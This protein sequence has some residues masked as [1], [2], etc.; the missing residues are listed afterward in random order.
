MSYNI[1]ELPGYI[2]TA[3]KVT[4]LTALVGVVIFMVAFLLN[5]G[6]KEIQQVGADFATTSVTVLNT[7][8]QWSVDAQE[9]TESS[10][11]TP[12]N[13]ESEVAWVATATDSNDE[14]Y[15][16]LICNT[17]VAPSSTVSGA[18]TCNSPIQWA[19]SASTTSGSE[20][21]AATTTTESFNESNDWYAWICDGIAANPRCNAAP[22]Q[23]TA[24]TA[25][26][27]NVNHR[28]VFTAFS[29]NSES[30]NAVP[31]D[32]VT[33]YAT[34]T[35]TDTVDAQDTLQLIVCSTASFNTVTDT[36]DVSTLA[37]S[38]LTAPDSITAT[39]F[40]RPPMRDTTYGA[41]GYVID[42]HGH[43]SVGATQGS[44][45]VM[46]VNNVAP[47]VTGAQ[48]SLNDGNPIVLTQEAGETTDLTLSFT[49]SDNNSCV[50]ISS[51]DEIVD[52]Q[53]SIYRSGVGSTTCD[54]TG[55]SL[56]VNDCYDNS[57]AST[58][59][60]LSCTASSTSC[61][62]IGTTD[63]LFECTFPLWYV[64][65]PTSGTSTQT[66]YSTQDW[67]ASVAP[68]DDNT[69]TGTM[70]ETSFPVE[71]NSFMMFSLDTPAIPYGPLEPGART[72]PLKASTTLRATGNVGLD[73]LLSGHHMCKD[74]S[75]AFKC[76]N[77]ATSTIADQ[78]Q[79]FSTTESASYASA[80]STGNIIS[81]STE[82]EL[83]L[84]VLKPTSTSTQ[85]FGVTYWGIE[86][87]ISITLAGAY[88]GE[89]TI[90]GKVSEPA[91][92]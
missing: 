66:F 85:T 41:F 22:R 34:S 30:A 27:F 48:I 12:T 7:P 60:N 75:T 55:T 84:N 37:T 54:G 24:T 3:G 51:G 4:V 1:K 69:A 47:S 29:D 92:W 15:Y 52:Y 68:I 61:G 35:D 2:N 57:V 90:Y 62:G 10:T 56:N 78:Y 32:T 28:P 26:P 65:D 88:T 36:C 70:T 31:G 91:Q 13:S 42:V 43:E 25:S 20:A 8:P 89:N 76:N 77:S 72:D 53:V 83:E 63:Q 16:L 19:V 73:E 59:W 45:T 40:I 82:K 18:P 11:T 74:Y 80:T 86:V 49:A 44:N 58:T 39:Y 50:N 23:G 81:S 6:A 87:P 71:L 64:A 46:T 33:F 38:T 21:R 67:R 5:I 14:D 17:S 9:E 79:V